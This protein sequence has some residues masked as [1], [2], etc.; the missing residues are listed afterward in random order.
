MQQLGD[1]CVT[2]GSGA[3][4]QGGDLRVAIHNDSARKLGWYGLGRGIAL[5]IARGI[6]FLHSRKV[7]HRDVKSK[8]IL[9]DEVGGSPL[10]L[11]LSRTAAGMP[12]T[13][14]NIGR[15]Y[16][17]GRMTKYC[18]CAVSALSKTPRRR[19]TAHDAIICRTEPPR[20]AG[21]RGHGED[22]DAGRA[23]QP[24]VGGL[25]DGHLRVGGA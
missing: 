2:P 22:D 13:P 3:W 8:N 5:D 25:R 10:Q 15:W 24:P 1:M 4:L 16:P 14:A 17:L 23:R 19:L 12:V 6:A 21:G 11:C 18:A 20:E 9:L 7:I